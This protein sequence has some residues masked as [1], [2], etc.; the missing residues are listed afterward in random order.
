MS[1]SDLNELTLK[2]LQVRASEIYDELFQVRGR[3]A[4]EAGSNLKQ[5]RSLR[6][7]L[8]RIKTLIRTKRGA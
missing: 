1:A 7:E 3:L 5:Y 2:D 8:A 4:Y 6:K